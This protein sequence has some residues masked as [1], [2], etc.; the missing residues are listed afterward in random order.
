MEED[1]DDLSIKE[2]S[3]LQKYAYV[4]L[5]ALENDHIGFCYRENS[6]IKID[7][8][9]RF[10]YGDEDEDYL[11][12]PDN[13]ETKDLSEVLKWKSQISQILNERP[14]KEFEWDEDEKIFRK[15]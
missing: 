13:T 2:Y 8:G 5:R 15:Y 11:E 14:G 10:M 6:E 3:D 1:W 7:S 12:N 4:T 9:W